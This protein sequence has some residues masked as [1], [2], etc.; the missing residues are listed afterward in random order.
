MPTFNDCKVLSQYTSHKWSIRRES[1]FFAHAHDNMHM[2]GQDNDLS[3]SELSK[4]G[5][6]VCV[7]DGRREGREGGTKKTQGFSKHKILYLRTPTSHKWSIREE[8]LFSTHWNIHVL[9]VQLWLRSSTH[10]TLHLTGVWNQDFQIMN[11]ALHVP[12]TLA[13]T[14]EPSGTVIRRENLFSAH[15]DIHAL[16]RPSE[17]QQT[18]ANNIVTYNN[19]FSINVTWGVNNSM[20]VAKELL[21]LE[22][23]V[24][25]L[26]GSCH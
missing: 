24:C 11:R 15:W 21:C 10:P 25:I 12:E 9:L 13:L 16:T 18:I 17:S 2:H 1:L 4:T 5:A 14:T 19:G 23:E 26:L 22:K 7:V 6:C 3:I 20:H 8:N